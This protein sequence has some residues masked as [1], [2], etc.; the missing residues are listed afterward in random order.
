MNIQEWFPL[1]LTSLI[2]LKSKVLS[3]A[4]SKPEFKSINS[5]ALSILYSPTSTFMHDYYKSYGFD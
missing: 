4:S 5:S 1:E 2:S 3:R